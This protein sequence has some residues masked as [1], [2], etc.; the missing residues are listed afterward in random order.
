[1]TANVT[2]SYGGSLLSRSAAFL[3]WRLLYQLVAQALMRPFLVV[4]ILELR[5]Q[6]IHVRATEDYKV[7]QNLLLN[8]L[9]EP[10]DKGYHVGGS[11]GS[12]L[13][14]DA[15]SLEGIQKRL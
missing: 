14:L 13:G 5:T 7:I 11:N 8:C 1:M 3:R 10:L 15:G 2:E 4:M 6:H 12:P 9:D